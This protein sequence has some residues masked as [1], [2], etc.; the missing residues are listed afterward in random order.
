MEFF[1]IIFFEFQGLSKSENLS[2]VMVS[3]TQPIFRWFYN[4]F[5]KFFPGL[6]GNNQS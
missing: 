5:R 2:R 3:S 6:F 4:I 1:S